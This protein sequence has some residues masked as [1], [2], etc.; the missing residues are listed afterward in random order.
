ML[1]DISVSAARAVQASW[2]NVLHSYMS[3]QNDLYLK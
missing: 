2:N 1:I 3:D